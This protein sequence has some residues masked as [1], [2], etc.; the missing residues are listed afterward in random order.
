MAA[1]KMYLFQ[2]ERPH[3][4]LDLFNLMPSPYAATKFAFTLSLLKD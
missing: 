2:S 1:D 4:I 3:G